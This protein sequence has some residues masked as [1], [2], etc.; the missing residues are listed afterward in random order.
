[1]VYFKIE[2]S[3]FFILITDSQEVRLLWQ[4]EQMLSQTL[5]NLFVL[6]HH[7]DKLD[8]MAK[9]TI[10]KPFCVRISFE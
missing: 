7:L 2:K 3:I 4:M 6:N 10:D 1:M 8:W 9:L 5:M